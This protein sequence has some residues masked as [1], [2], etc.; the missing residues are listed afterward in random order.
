[1]TNKAPKAP[2]RML[3]YNGLRDKGVPFHPNYLRHLWEH[4]QF[5]KPVRLSA[6][7]LAWLESDVDAWIEERIRLADS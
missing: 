1:M 2:K 6:R 4:G 7:K 5:P 3:D